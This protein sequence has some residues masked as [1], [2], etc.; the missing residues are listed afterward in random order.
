MADAGRSPLNAPVTEGL[1]PTTRPGAKPVYFEKERG[2][3]EVQIVRGIAHTIVTLPT[4]NE[5]A[6]R[7][8]LLKALASASVPVFMVKI[9]SGSLSFAIRQSAIEAGEAVMNTVGYPYQMNRDL[10]TLSIV[11]GAMRDLSGVM[12]R[13]YEALVGQGIE[14]YQ[15]GDAYNAVHCLVA[16]SDA[17]KGAQALHK[18]F[19]L[20]ALS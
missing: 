1:Q 13:I 9:D 15:T 6:A 14:V 7:L 20:E 8:A 5:D 10:A 16:G 2:V 17:D 12:A 19:E 11:A 18:A 4:E 3:T